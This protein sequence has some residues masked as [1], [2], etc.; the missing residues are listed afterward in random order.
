MMILIVE[1]D[2][3]ATLPKHN[4][5]HEQGGIV[6]EGEL[7]FEIE[8]ETRLLHPGDLYIIPGGVD[9]EVKV[10]GTPA[11]VLDIFSPV[12]EEYKD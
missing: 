11:K 7:E 1:L 12:R 3:N 5:P 4:H 6:L 8:G 9:H 10:R 2:A